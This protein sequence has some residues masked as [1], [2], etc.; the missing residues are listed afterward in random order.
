MGKLKTWKNNAKKI[1]VT[2]T[3]KKLTEKINKNKYKKHQK[4]LR[5][6]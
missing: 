5:N 6:M 1:R 4:S 2:N 3:D